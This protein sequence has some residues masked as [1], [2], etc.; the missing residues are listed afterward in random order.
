MNETIVLRF[1]RQP[2]SPINSGSKGGHTRQ[3]LRSR[4]RP[5]EANAYADRQRNYATPD[6]TCPYPNPPYVSYCKGYHQ[7]YDF[8]WNTSIP[9]SQ[10]VTKHQ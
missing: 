6:D 3:L 10:Q 5:R 2:T 7:A 4:V 1:L 9:S 8:N